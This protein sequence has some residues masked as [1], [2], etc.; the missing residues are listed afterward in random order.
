M[1]GENR[2]KENKRDLKTNHYKETRNREKTNVPQ[3]W[4]KLKKQTI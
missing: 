4:N 2:I 3:K 1:G